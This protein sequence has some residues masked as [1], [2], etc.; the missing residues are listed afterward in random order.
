MKITPIEK[1]LFNV[2]DKMR[3]ETLG[4]YYFEGQGDQKYLIV[5]V[6]SKMTPIERKAVAIHELVE[7]TLLELKGITPAMVDKWDT[8]DTGGKH[9]PKMYDKNAHYKAADK[10]ALMVE[11][12]IIKWSGK[13]WS[14][15]DKKLDDIVIK[16]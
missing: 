2:S 8:E 13:K 4:D 6:Y 1:I 9:D 15:Y 5:E 10:F 7:Q 16:W 12:E 14:E 11:K 3:Y